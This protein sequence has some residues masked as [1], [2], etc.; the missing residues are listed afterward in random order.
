MGYILFKVAI[1]EPL[2]VSLSKRKGREKVR[3]TVQVYGPASEAVTLETSEQL[4][5]DIPKIKD[6]VTLMEEEMVGLVHTVSTVTP[7]TI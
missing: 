5:W 6:V 7:S 4:W 2:L 3:L 1:T